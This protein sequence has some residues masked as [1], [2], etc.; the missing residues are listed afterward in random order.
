MEYGCIA[1]GSSGN[2]HYLKD[3]NGK[4]LLLD[5]GTDEM[6]IKKAID[7]QISNVVVALVTHSHNDHSACLNRFKKMGIET[8]T[9]YDGE[10]GY[11]MTFVKKF[12]DF[13]VT[14]FIL[15]DGAGTFTHTN[16]DG[17]QCPIYGYLIRHREMGSMIYVTDTEYVRWNFKNTKVNHFL[18][19]VDYDES[20]VDR[21]KANF[22]HVVEGHM[23]IDTAKEFVKSNY[24]SNTRNIIMCHLSQDVDRE[25]FVSEIRKVVDE[26]VS[27]RTAYKSL[28]TQL[29]EYPF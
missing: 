12:G 20:V 5:L 16:G 4:I 25:R 7:F 11:P 27:V 14:A 18:I 10:N 9:P 28:T 23:N 15:N 29:K 2:C 17:S 8:F 1:T 13:V 22:A 21:T 19:G 24:T 6:S 26:D 3:R